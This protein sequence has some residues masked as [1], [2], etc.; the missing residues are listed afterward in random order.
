MTLR[1][2]VLVIAGLALAGGLAMLVSG[3]FP[4][5]LGFTIFAGLILLGTLYEKVRYKPVEAA[6]PG[7]EWRRTPERFHDPENNELLTVYVNAAGERL[8]VKE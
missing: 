7:P 6:V 5:A 3:A 8:Y 4:A 1:A 2:A